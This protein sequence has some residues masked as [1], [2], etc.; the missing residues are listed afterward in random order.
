MVDDLGAGLRQIRRNPGYAGAVALTLALGVG[1]TTAVFTLADPMLFR[2]LPYPDADRM[3]AV[4]VS[5][6]GTT[7]GLL[8][9]S[10]SPLARSRASRPRGARRESI[11]LWR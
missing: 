7:G 10:P 6:K 11:R 5:A 2:P 1:A 4:T 8:P 9:C 3:V